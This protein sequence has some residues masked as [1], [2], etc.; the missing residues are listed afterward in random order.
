MKSWGISIASE[1]KTRALAKTRVTT[2]VVVEAVPFTFSLKRG[3][4][5][6]RAAPLVYIPHLEDKIW[7]LLDQNKRLVYVHTHV[8]THHVNSFLDPFCVYVYASQPQS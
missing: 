8:H 2:Q 4:E 6:V 3:G 1:R 5:E 7:E